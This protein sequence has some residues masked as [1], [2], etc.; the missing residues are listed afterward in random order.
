M[1]VK[2]EFFLIPKPPASANGREFTLVDL[3]GTDLGIARTFRLAVGA[4]STARGRTVFDQ[5][6]HER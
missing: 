6:L 5:S 2:R 1:R 3:R 4:W